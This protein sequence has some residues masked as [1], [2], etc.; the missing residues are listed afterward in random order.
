MIMMKMKISFCFEDE[1]KMM[2]LVDQNIIWDAGHDEGPENEN[3]SS[4]NRASANHFET[5]YTHLIAFF[6]Y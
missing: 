2:W 6:N 5:R 3:P 4:Y 1:M